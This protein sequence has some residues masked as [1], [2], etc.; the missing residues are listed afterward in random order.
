MK[1]LISVLCILILLSCDGY[2]KIL[3]STDYEFKLTK[4]HEYFEQHMFM[5]AAQ[6]YEELVPVFKGT[7]KAELLYYRYAWSEFNIGDYL[8]SQFHFKNYTRQFPNGLYVE[9]S[10]YMN[11]Y[12]YYLN[13][14]HYKLDQTYTEN[15]L[16]E[17][18]NFI[19]QFPESHKL[20]TC[21]LLMDKLHEKLERKEFETIKQYMQLADW[22]AA[23]MASEQFYKSYPTSNRTEELMLYH[24]DA[25]FQLARNSVSSKMADRLQ[26][27]Q[28]QY[29]KFVSLFPESSY[30]S[31]AESISKN[32]LAL[33]EK[34][35]HYGF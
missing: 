18:Q 27:V 16:A 35:I 21:N 19:D 14:P 10:L 5:R 31:R 30:L 9:T 22:K 28:D 20:D 6:L 26:L 2:N 11:A 24:L 17:L 3:R 13:S 29:V 34:L 1:F 7:D 25:Q 33:K 32:A 4:A 12:C 23:I 8:L 15:A